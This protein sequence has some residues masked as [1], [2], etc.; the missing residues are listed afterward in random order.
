MEMKFKEDPR[1]H[2]PV[3][4]FL[5]RCRIKVGKWRRADLK[6]IDESNE[7]RQPQNKILEASV[8]SLSHLD[9]CPPRQGAN[10]LP[11]SFRHIVT[12]TSESEVA[13]IQAPS[14][15]RQPYYLTLLGQLPRELRDLV[16]SRV[17]ANNGLDI[18]HAQ[19]RGFSDVNVKKP[20]TQLK[21]LAT[22]RQ[23]FEEAYS[24]AYRSTC[25]YYFTYQ[26]AGLEHKLA[27]FSPKQ[28]KDIHHLASW[29]NPYLPSRLIIQ[30]PPGLN[31]QKLTVSCNY[32]SGPIDNSNLQARI[33]WVF[34]T[35]ELLTSLKNLDFLTGCASR[36][37]TIA[38]PPSDCG[39]AVAVRALLLSSWRNNPQVLKVNTTGS[40]LTTFE[41]FLKGGDN[42][43]A[44]M[45]K[46]VIASIYE[47]DAIVLAAKDQLSKAEG[48]RTREKAEITDELAT[49]IDEETN[50]QGVA[51]PLP[52]FS[53]ASDVE[54]CFE[55][56]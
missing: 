34:E 25:F 44:R 9:I 49:T 37:S 23:F 45:V 6:P 24:I 18:V 50:S 40:S 11:D 21:V 19:L 53:N 4:R 20:M 17:F 43:P 2:N 13:T 15:P 5:R 39:T 47:L 48:S 1:V 36:L 52:T 22:C 56:P 3:R 31:I 10:T 35:M 30:I 26:R 7:Q 12:P 14:T 32:M 16:Y 46:L 54:Q 55:P 51:D 41:V 28:R 38:D 27:R 33:P 42:K 8:T 29:S